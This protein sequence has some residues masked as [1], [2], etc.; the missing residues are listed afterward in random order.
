MVNEKEEMK[1]RKEYIVKLVDK[2]SG[3]THN[4]VQLY[5]TS[6]KEAISRA[7]NIAPGDKTKFVRY[8][9]TTGRKEG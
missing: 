6:K 7:K 2:K 9:K 1:I 4:T 5:A 3:Q 8:V